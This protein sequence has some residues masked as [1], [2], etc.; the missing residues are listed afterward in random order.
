MGLVYLHQKVNLHLLKVFKLRKLKLMTRKDFHFKKK[1]FFYYLMSLLTANAPLIILLLL[2]IVFGYSS[3]VVTTVQ[4]PFFFSSGLFIPICLLKSKAKIVFSGKE[5]KQFTLFLTAFL[6]LFTAFVG[7][8][9]TLLNSVY[10]SVNP[11]GTVDKH[12]GFDQ[13][14]VQVNWGFFSVGLVVIVFYL[15]WNFFRDEGRGFVKKLMDDSALKDFQN[16][17]K[18]LYSRQ[19]LTNLPNLVNHYK[20]KALEDL[21]RK[22]ADIEIRRKLKLRYGEKEQKL[23]I[24]FKFVWNV[25]LL[26]TIL[27]IRKEDQLFMLALKRRIHYAKITRASTINGSYMKRISHYSVIIYRGHVIDKFN[28]EYHIFVSS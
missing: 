5:T 3:Q 16:L 25:R 20:T 1:L 10:F 14:L 18:Q 22:E 4:S 28:I 12:S 21:R 19:Q 9:N 24:Y 2:M 11:S 13:H 23:N 7:T 8:R 26:V 15:F 6:L 17:P 27:R